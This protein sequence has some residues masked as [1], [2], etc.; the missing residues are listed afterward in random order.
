MGRCAC[1]AGED[2]CDLAAVVR[3]RDGCDGREAGAAVQPG[4]RGGQQARVEPAPGVRDDVDLLGARKPFIQP[5]AK[6]AG[7]ALHGVQVAEGEPSRFEGGPN[8]FST[9][10][11]SDL[12]RLQQLSLRCPPLPLPPHAIINIGELT[13]P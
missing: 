6:L 3:G 8:P 9:F 12:S 7:A 4:R 11:E 2:V 5:I 13:L 1:R 10:C